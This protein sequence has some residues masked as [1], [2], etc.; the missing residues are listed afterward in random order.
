MPRSDLNQLILDRLDRIEN[1]QNEL[2]NRLT[3]LI[4]KTDYKI[5]KISERVACLESEIK[6]KNEFDGIMIAKVSA[7]S[8]VV[9]TLFYIFSN[10]I[11][12]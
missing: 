7:V 10:L 4:E 6:A 12:I 1:N 2:S 3:E 8:A 9:S 11:K 5:A